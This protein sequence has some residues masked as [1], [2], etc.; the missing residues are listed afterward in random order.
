MIEFPN[1]NLTECVVTFRNIIG[2][3]VVLRNCLYRSHID[4]YGGL[5]DCSKR[6]F[7]DKND[8]QEYID[9]VNPQAVTA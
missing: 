2:V 9:L 5:F 7:N 6:V 3:R 4:S 8:A 1:K